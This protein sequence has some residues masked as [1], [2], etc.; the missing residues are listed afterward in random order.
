MKIRQPHDVFKNILSQLT[1]GKIKTDSTKASYILN[2][3]FEKG[4]TNQ[5]SVDPLIVK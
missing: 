5:I 1:A 3:Y 4:K 2:D